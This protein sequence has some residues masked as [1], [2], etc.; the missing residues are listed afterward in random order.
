MNKKNERAQI[1]EKRGEKL[2]KYFS[3]KVIIGIIVA[4]VLVVGGI[5]M[6]KLFFTESKTTKIGF[7]DIGK[8]VTQAAY[9]TEVSVTDSSRELF[10]VK[11][12]FTQSKY[13]YSYDVVVEAGIDFNE[14]DWF[15]TDNIITVKLPEVT[16]S[17]AIKLDSFKIYHEAESVYRQISMEENNEALKK[18]E[19]QAKA[20]AEANGLRENARRNAETILKGFFGKQY[21]MEKYKIKFLDK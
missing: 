12:P 8:L 20:D 18:L 3:G 13:I 15:V 2:K 11:I 17:P 6:S 5:S 16:L 4:L 19:Q 7:E 10:G 1:D 14:I 21:D 9:C